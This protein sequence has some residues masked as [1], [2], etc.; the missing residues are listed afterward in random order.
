MKK[1]R[2]LKS[3]CI[4]DM[5]KNLH[6]IYKENWEIDLLIVSAARQVELIDQTTSTATATSCTQWLPVTLPQSCY[7]SDICGETSLVGFR[8]L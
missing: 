4:F 5:L 3:D 7:Q 2:N 8:C 6:L 1:W